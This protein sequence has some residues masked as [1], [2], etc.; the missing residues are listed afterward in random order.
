[1]KPIIP[2]VLTLIVGINA[3]LESASKP[4][5][6]EPCYEN[7]T[8]LIVII[9]ESEDSQK[10]T[11]SYMISDALEDKGEYAI[12][13]SNHLLNTIR[14]FDQAYAKDWDARSISENISL[15]VPK[16]LSSWYK[17]SGAAKSIS[18]DYVLG[19]S[20][21]TLK[22]L[23]KKMLTSRRIGKE[24][25][26]RE[27]M[28]ALSMIFIP[29][30]DYQKKNIAPRE[31]HLVFIGHGV[32][33]IQYEQPTR[34]PVIKAEGRISGFVVSDLRTLLF[35]LGGRYLSRSEEIQKGLK[36]AKEQDIPGKISIA[37]V[38]MVSCYTGDLN[39]LSVFSKNQ[40]KIGEAY[41]FSYP[42]ILSTPL[43][44]ESR[45]KTDRNDF[46]SFFNTIRNNCLHPDF[47]KALKYIFEYH[48]KENIPVIKQPGIPIFFPL[49][50]TAYI[51]I[52]AILGETRTKTLR[53]P[54]DFGK[55]DPRAILIRA[56]IINA[57]LFIEP[58]N[59]LPPIF[60]IREG[61]STHDF[62]DGISAPSYTFTDLINA[63]L[64]TKQ[65]TW[66]AFRFKTLTTR[67]TILKK[68]GQVRTFND[69]YIINYVTPYE[70]AGLFYQAVKIAVSYAYEGKQYLYEPKTQEK[71]TPTLSENMKPH[72]TDAHTLLGLATK[73]L[74]EIVKEIEKNPTIAGTEKPIRSVEEI[75]KVLKR[76]P[77][78][79]AI[80]LFAQ[81]LHQL[82]TQARKG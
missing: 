78:Q 23:Q 70:K 40:E 50:P 64:S 60:S 37:S 33:P 5:T 77:P 6:S 34:G 79:K 12:I 42:I 61:P 15:L 49:D 19:M 43:A 63:F 32:P 28:D 22:P 80:D 13:T 67:D 56:P 2:Y 59:T 3:T 52:G 76:D 74:W 65:K 46:S 66:K 44:S 81:S 10:A 55:T 39:E 27:A 30:T 71:G 62:T 82:L 20:L 24:K 36:Y 14:Y 51:E 47:E 58:M 57:A 17:K 45:S 53:I 4:A 68:D 1:M 11:V 26:S 75:E 31:Y 72:I 73:Q 41:Q 9:D 69:V 8:P 38:T 54:S 29:R 18:P 16:N 21:T 7:F 25:L 35:T 48:K